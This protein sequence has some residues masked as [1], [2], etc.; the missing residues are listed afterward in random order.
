MGLV[1]GRGLSYKEEGQS[2]LPH[3]DIRKKAEQKEA[4]DRINDKCHVNKAQR[5]RRLKDR[6][7]SSQEPRLKEQ[8]WGGR[9]RRGRDSWDEQRQGSQVLF[10]PLSWGEEQI[11]APIFQ[12]EFLGERTVYLTNTTPRWARLNVKK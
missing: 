2:V 4:G 9:G 11:I 3:R 7:R 1:A 10:S 12:L 5:G 6:V 8:A